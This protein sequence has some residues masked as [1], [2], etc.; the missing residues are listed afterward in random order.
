MNT[1]ARMHAYTHTGQIKATVAEGVGRAQECRSVGGW[2][3]RRLLE[4]L[5]FFNFLKKL[6]YFICMKVWPVYL[7]VQHCVCLMHTETRRECQISLD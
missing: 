5:F 1:H 6:S 3:N 2:D 7:S 4:F